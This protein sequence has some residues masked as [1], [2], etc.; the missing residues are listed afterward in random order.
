MFV[1]G[2]VTMYLI[3]AK[4]AATAIKNANAKIAHGVAN[5]HGVTR[6]RYN[7]KVIGNY[8]VVK[9]RNGRQKAIPIDRYRRLRR[10]RSVCSVLGAIGSMLLICGATY[11]MNRPE[12]AYAVMIQCVIAVLLLIVCIVA[13]VGR[14]D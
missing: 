3:A 5:L 13:A 11:D 6:R 12:T 8:V 14:S 2:I 1:Y 4:I 7:M 9:R 10:I